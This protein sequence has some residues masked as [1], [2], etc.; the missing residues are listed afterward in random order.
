M[1]NELEDALDFF[2]VD[3]LDGDAKQVAAQ[4]CQDRI[5]DFVEQLR[6][7]WSPCATDSETMAALTHWAHRELPAAGLE[8]GAIQR[9]VKVAGSVVLRYY[10]LASC[11]L[12]V[13]MGRMT[14]IVINVDDLQDDEELARQIAQFSDMERAGGPQSQ[15]QGWL[16]LFSAGIQDLAEYFGKDDD[17]VANMVRT[18]WTNW[19]LGWLIEARLA[20]ASSA[21]RLPEA[22]DGERGQAWAKD[23]SRG[24]LQPVNFPAYLRDKTG[25][26]DA[27]LFPI[28]RPSRTHATGMSHW[29]ESIADIQLYINVVNDVLSLPKE[30]LAGEATNF[31]GHTARVGHAAGQPGS[32]HDGLYCMRDVLREQCKAVQDAATRVDAQMAGQGG[33][34]AE[35]WRAF[36]HGYVLWHLECPRYGLDRARE[37]IR[38]AGLT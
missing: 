13:L 14:A 21:S 22:A 6:L 32:G 37:R 36:R 34:Q 3:L 35:L 4:A 29:M 26:A 31:F 7:V 24:K 9:T 38:A 11:E 25:V 15:P 1:T 23:E 19:L 18:S 17:L 5:V 28:F 20:S 8:E 16:R 30:I 27:F 33:P 12:R 10:P 2:D